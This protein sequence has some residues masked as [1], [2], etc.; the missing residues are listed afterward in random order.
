MSYFKSENEDLNRLRNC[1]I[2]I[3]SMKEAK[4][5]ADIL[6]KENNG[7]IIICDTFLNENWIIKEGVSIVTDW[8]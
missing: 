2:V 8:F 4:E 1:V 5:I 7:K 3:Q 6:I